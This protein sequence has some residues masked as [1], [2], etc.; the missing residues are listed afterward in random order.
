M[1]TND[2]YHALTRRQILGGLGAVGLASAGAGLGTS[3]YFN[4]TESFDN[5]TLQAGEL[6]LKLDYR[7]TYA[8]GPGRLSDIQSTYPDAEE[9]STGTYLLGEAPNDWGAV[10]RDEI[11]CETDGLVN[12]EAIP[13][14]DL[15]D[16]KPGDSGEVTT[17][18]HLCGNPSYIRM[19]ACVTEDENGVNE[20]ESDVDTSPEMAELANLLDVRVW[21]DPDCDNL[22]DEGEHVIYEGT[23]AGLSEFACAGVPLVSET[24]GSGEAC[25]KLGRLE[26]LEGEQFQTVELADG[27][28]GTAN[29]DIY[30]FDDGTGVEPQLQLSN[31]Q[32]EDGEVVGFDVEVLTDG[33]GICKALVKSGSATEEYIFGECVDTTT[34]LGPISGRPNRVRQE[35]S[36]VE[37]W[38]CET[39]EET[40]CFQPGT[41]CVGFEWALPASVGNEVQ[42]DI[43]SFDLTFE[44]EQCRH[45]ENPAAE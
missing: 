7:A 10:E 43:A 6:D 2:R 22:Y 39:V 36:H 45:N 8:G 27:S 14:F 33:V 25:T 28:D 1:T 31:F 26:D 4:D 9:L 41:H 5:N 35:V 20:P 16:V 3:A 42:T 40:H 18:L 17:S 19:K 32:E 15:D 29:G 23:L 13:V 38:T 21:R 24:G 11:T 30:T 12:G 34:L 37:F 44:A